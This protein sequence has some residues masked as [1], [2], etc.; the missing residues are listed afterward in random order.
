MVSW[1]RTTM[2]AKPAPDVSWRFV[3]TIA[4]VYLI[5]KISAERFYILVYTLM[6]LVGVK[7]L[8]D[9]VA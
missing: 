6:I 9:G 3:S 5:R 4:G 7:L 1:L 2:T 8:W